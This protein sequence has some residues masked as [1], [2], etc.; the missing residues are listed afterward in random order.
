M[1]YY[2]DI[3]AD[4]RPNLMGGSNTDIRSMF[5]TVVCKVNVV[6]K[7][8]WHRMGRRKEGNLNEW[9]KQTK[10]Q[11]H[12]AFEVKFHLRISLNCCKLFQ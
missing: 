2:R 1:L 6:C 3:P 9:T 12:F 5:C 7:C 10:I 11:R 4:E 8:H